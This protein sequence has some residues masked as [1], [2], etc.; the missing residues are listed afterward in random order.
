MLLFVFIVAFLTYVAQLWNLS[1]FLD[2][3]FGVACFEDRSA[4]WIEL[5]D[6]DRATD[7]CPWYTLQFIMPN[8]DELQEGQAR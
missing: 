5:N 1:L 4:C 3:T 2:D 8:G 7:V 6:C